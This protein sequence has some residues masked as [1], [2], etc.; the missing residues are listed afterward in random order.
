MVL[1]QVQL[2]SDL[3]LIQLYHWPKESINETVIIALDIN[4][5]AL[6]APSNTSARSVLD[7]RDHREYQVG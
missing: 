2:F 5:E 4:K 7:P 3:Y 1:S 6:Q